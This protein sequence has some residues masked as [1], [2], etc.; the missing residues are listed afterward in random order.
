VILFGKDQ[1]T[2][3]DLEYFD[4]EDVDAIYDGG[5]GGAGALDE[6]AQGK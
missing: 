5:T 3:G 4:W 6:G 2:L 1:I